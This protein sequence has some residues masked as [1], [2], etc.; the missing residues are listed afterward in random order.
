MIDFPRTM[1]KVHGVLSNHGDRKR[2]KSHK[3]K[4]KG[5]DKKSKSKNVNINEL[6]FAQQIQIRC[7]AGV[8]PG[9]KKPNC[10]L[11]EKIPKED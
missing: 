7:W 10:R 9:H 11:I 6:I 5:R 2:G 3:P 8:K 4:G 1:V